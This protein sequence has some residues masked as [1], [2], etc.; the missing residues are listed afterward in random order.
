MLSLRPCRSVD[1]A[2]A[3]LIVRE[4]GGAVAFG[5]LALEEAGLGLDARYPMPPPP[6]SR[7]GAWRRP[8][9]PL[10]N[11]SREAV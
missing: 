2:A 1:A 10:R 8:K 3:Q 7:H 9:P 6:A 11:P 4:A 5:D